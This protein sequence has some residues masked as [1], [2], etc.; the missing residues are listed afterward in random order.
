MEKKKI[1]W[2]NSILDKKLKEVKKK[3]LSSK[4]LKKNFREHDKLVLHAQKIR[5]WSDLLL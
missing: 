3:M 2:E 5:T 1:E 4:Q